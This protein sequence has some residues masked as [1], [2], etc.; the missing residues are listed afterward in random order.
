MADL[1][2]YR[3]ILHYEELT[4]V[5][6]RLRSNE[7][8]NDPFFQRYGTGPAQQFDTDDVTF[9]VI[10]D[11]REAAPL[12]SR[13]QPA[14]VLE[15]GGVSEAS[16]TMIRS[17]NALPLKG[18]AM[19]AL[20]EPESHSLQRKAEQV[21]NME[22]LRFAKRHAITQRQIVAKL[23]QGTT[24]YVG[25]DGKVLESATNA[26]YSIATGIPTKNLGTVARADHGIGDGTGNVNATLWTDPA[27]KIIDQLDE[28][29]EAAEVVGNPPLVDV[30]QH[31]TMKRYMRANTQL[32]T[33]YGTD[34]EGFVSAVGR[35][36]G[37]TVG[38]Y[39]FR[40]Y[41]GKYTAAGGG[42]Q[43]YLNP[44]L[45]IVTPEGTDFMLLGDGLELIPDSIDIRTSIEE[46]RNGMQEVYGDFSHASLEFNPARLSLYGGFNKLFGFRNP[47]AV[48]AITVSA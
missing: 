34:E 20:R 10:D 39:N 47:S 38:Q 26:A 16:L 24:I 44:T 37:F 41:G 31:V 42:S 32:Q 2:S 48:F 11:D 35:A 43:N 7:Q 19:Q 12:N 36:G 25:A 4:G 21:I 29:N 30:W 6:S 1:E 40:F 28:L 17:Y 5:Y 33:E 22:S 18:Y 46:A 9:L 23:F 3:E 13:D 8:E 27:A 15:P 45:A 14:R